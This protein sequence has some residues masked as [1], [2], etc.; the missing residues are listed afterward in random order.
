MAV[1][2]QAA[3]R[4]P[5][6]PVRTLHR[7]DFVWCAFPEREA[8]LRPGSPHVAYTIAIG[9]IAGRN[10]AV[11]A[12]TT[13][14]AWTGPKPPGVVV[15]GPEEAAQ[16]GQARGFVLDLRRM[17]YL[18]ITT[19]WF[20]RLDEPKGGVLGSA[21]KGLRGRLDRIAFELATRRPEWLSRLGPLRS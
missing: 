9:I 15:F 13:S 6:I 16:L 12:Y 11:V 19:T 10:M 1:V 8:P 21:S 14:R 5:E 7:G 20:P 2:P 3:P 18:P 4:G 17:A